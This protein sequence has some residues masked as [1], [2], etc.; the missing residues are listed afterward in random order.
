MKRNDLL[1]LLKALGVEDALR[2]EQTRLTYS[3]PRANNLFHG[4]GGSRTTSTQTSSDFRIAEL[5]GLLALNDPHISKM[6]WRAVSET[7]V[8]CMYAYYAPNQTYEPHRDLSTLAFTLR[9]TAW[10]PAK[11]N[12]LRRPSA[13]SASELAA[14]F[15][16]AGNDA[17]L[18]VIDFGA[19]HRQRSEQHFARRRAAQTIGLSRRTSRQAGPDVTRRHRIPQHGDAEADRE[20]SILG[21]SFP[22]T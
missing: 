9:G 21:T 7:G 4:F 6:V 8:H 17:W 18:N 19:D 1:A 12:T 2:V 3:H 20:R 14:G 5:P 16:I 22:G 13:I 10:I 11:D 15:S